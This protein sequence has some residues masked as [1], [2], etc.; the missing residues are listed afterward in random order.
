MDEEA[1]E[2]ESGAEDSG[3]HGVNPA[4]P[5]AKKR[6]TVPPES[7]SFFY[8]AHVSSSSSTLATAAEDEAAVMAAM[9]LPTSLKPGTAESA[10]DEYTV[11]RVEPPTR[12]DHRLAD[13]T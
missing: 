5:V 7:H 10:G 12:M 1:D 2:S 6:R 8:S 3:W 13:C 9:G 11:S 4:Q